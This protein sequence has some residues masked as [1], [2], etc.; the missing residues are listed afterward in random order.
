MASPACIATATSRNGTWPSRTW[1]APPRRCS[2][3]SSPA[4]RASGGIRV[5]ATHASP[6]HMQAI[7]HARP[8]VVA[9]RPRWQDARARQGLAMRTPSAG[10]AQAFSNIGHTLDHA[11]T[12]LFPTVVLVLELQW[13]MSYDELIALFIAAN[14]LFGVGALPAGW[15]GDRWSTMGMM[16]IYFIGLG[17]AT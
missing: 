14:I 4:W 9:M 11:L 12:T 3:C 15:L 8:V 10:L 16:V 1:R 5:G 13:G 17:A 2:T 7:R 6:L